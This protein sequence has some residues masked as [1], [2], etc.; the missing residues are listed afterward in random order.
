MKNLQALIKRETARVHQSHLLYQN[1]YK[2]L[3]LF[4]KNIARSERI[5]I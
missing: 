4:L 1:L 3:I 5:L 2:L